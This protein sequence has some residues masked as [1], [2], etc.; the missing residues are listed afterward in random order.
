MINRRFEQSPLQHCNF[1]TNCNFILFWLI[2]S[3]MRFWDY[4]D[5]MRNYCSR[6]WSLGF[7]A[8]YLSRQCEVDV[9]HIHGY[10]VC[11]SQFS[12]IVL[13]NMQHRV[14][15]NWECNLLRWKTAKTFR[16]ECIK[17]AFEKNFLESNYIF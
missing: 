9:D 11:N 17:E 12:V 8:L 4:T 6:F 10:C 15:E 1:P 3:T 16:F 7:E 14:I 5:T 13:I 2:N